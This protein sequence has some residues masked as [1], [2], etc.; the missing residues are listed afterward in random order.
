MTRRGGPY[1]YLRL[2]LMTKV[3][4]GQAVHALHL[5]ER[6]SIR[7][8]AEIL[9]LSPTTAWR[10]FWFFMDFTLPG[11]YGKPSGPIPPQRGTRAC[12]NG[13]PYLPTL[14]GGTR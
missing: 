10:R 13:R 11:Y 6:R 4:Q 9:G 12:P 2:D 14:D 7:E 5:G 8:S 1:P 3:E